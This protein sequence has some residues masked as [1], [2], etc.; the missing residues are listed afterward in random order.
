MGRVDA[1]VVDN[2]AACN[3]AVKENS[4]FE[5][6]WQGPFDEL[7]GICLKKGNDALTIALNN[8]LDELSSEGALLKISQNIFGDVSQNMMPSQ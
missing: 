6:V 1:V 5:I 3:Y 2:I 8:A 4:L 7:I